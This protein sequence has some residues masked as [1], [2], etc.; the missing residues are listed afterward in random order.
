MNP[1]VERIR[2]H[3]KGWCLV[4][5]GRAMCFELGASMK[6]QDPR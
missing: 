2:T 1:Y 5:E 3:K 6:H 4:V